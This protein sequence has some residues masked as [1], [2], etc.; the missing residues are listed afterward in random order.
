MTGVV[1]L[2]ESHISIHTWP[3]NG[4]AAADIF[5]CGAA[6]PQLALEVI[7]EALQPEPVEERPIADLLRLERELSM[8]A[9]RQFD[10]HYRLRPILRDIASARL[11]QRGLDIDSG[12]PQVEELLGDE[13]YELTTAEREPPAN[14]LAPGPG[15]DGLDRTIGRL[16]RL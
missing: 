8:A 10:L 1:L 2:A 7:E 4:F 16:E 6:Q 12:R 3:E 15:V 14:R 13:L 5:M 9:A 11:D